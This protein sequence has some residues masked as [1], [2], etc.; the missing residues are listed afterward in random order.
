MRLAS[1]IP[2]GLL[3][4]GSTPDGALL[5]RSIRPF[6]R[7]LPSL[8]AER[9]LNGNAECIQLGDPP[10]SRLLAEVQSNRTRV[11]GVRAIERH[12]R[13]AAPQ[14]ISELLLPTLQR[15]HIFQRTMQAGHPDAL[16]SA[17]AVHY[18]H[19]DTSLGCSV[20]ALAVYGQPSLIIS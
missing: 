6:A 17:S 10:E 13:H 16:A 20:I 7:S 14:N 1:T 2:C 5:V 9:L 8:A 18:G 19:A 4:G 15:L 3:P 12:N 11:N